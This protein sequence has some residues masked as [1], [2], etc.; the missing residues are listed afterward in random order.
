MWSTQG[1]SN[2][3]ID[4]KEA[5]TM[6]YGLWTHFEQSQFLGLS[7]NLPPAPASGITS[8]GSCASG[9]SDYWTYNAGTDGVP[10]SPD[11]GRFMRFEG[12]STAGGH[13]YMTI[14]SKDQ[15]NVGEK[16]TVTPPLTVPQCGTPC[17]FQIPTG[18]TTT[19]SW[20]QYNVGHCVASLDPE[21]T[22]GTTLRD[23]GLVDQNGVSVHSAQRNCVH[24][25]QNNWFHVTVNLTP[26]AGK[27]VKRWS[28]GYDESY[29]NGSGN[30][31]VYFDGI[32]INY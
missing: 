4:D 17:Y 28:V 3:T 11:G 8:Y 25:G 15:D 13:A 10:T 21:F 6:E 20:W 5:A 29:Y 31:R 1:L 27:T 2:L 22:D 9:T 23:S 26:L 12:C 32:A 30:W 18:R 19:L 7:P 16:D 24:Y 14:A